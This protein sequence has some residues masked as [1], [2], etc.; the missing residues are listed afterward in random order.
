MTGYDWKQRMLIDYGICIDCR[1]AIA[2]PFRRCRGCR[3]IL[4]ETVRKRRRRL[5][6]GGKKLRG[7]RRSVKK[8][9]PKPERRPPDWE[10]QRSSDMR[11]VE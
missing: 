2:L 10:Y 1:D 5:K 7:G 11:W 9:D 3:A 6:S 8:P 4:S